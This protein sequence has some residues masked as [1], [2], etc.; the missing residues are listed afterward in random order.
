MSHTRKILPVVVLVVAGLF[1]CSDSSSPADS[2]TC[3]DSDQSC[4]ENGG[5]LDNTTSCSVDFGDSAGTTGDTGTQDSG[6]STQ[7]PG[8]FYGDCD[9]KR[10]FP[11]LGPTDLQASGNIE[12]AG[13]DYGIERGDIATVD[14]G[15]YEGYA[16]TFGARGQCSPQLRVAFFDEPQAKVDTPLSL[17][18][19]DS[20]VCDQNQGPK[21]IAFSLQTENTCKHAAQFESASLEIDT[22]RLSPNQPSIRVDGTLSAE[23]EDNPDSLQASFTMS[24]GD[25]LPETQNTFTVDEALCN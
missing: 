25:E 18:L 22:V 24:S 6:T 12:F 15:K 11:Q 16:L 21:P 20:L 14:W 13:Q 10:L 23:L 8:D 5:I 7:S 2:S 19:S 4:V 9:S 1:G 3:S 17:N